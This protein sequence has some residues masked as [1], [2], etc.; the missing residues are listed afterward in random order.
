MRLM[1]VDDSA[2]A[3]AVLRDM[4][5]SL[6]CD[7]TECHDGWEAI[8][9]YR[10]NRPDWVLMDIH[11]P[12]LDG[13]TATAA[14]CKED[15]DARV[16]MVTHFNDDSFR[17]RALEVGASGFFSKEDLFSVLHFLKASNGTTDPRQ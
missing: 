15:P 14:L 8:Q 5:A 6:H 1:I 3:R 16:L 9:Q 13:I 10:M 7:I 11:M 4:L 12:G 2:A 17:D